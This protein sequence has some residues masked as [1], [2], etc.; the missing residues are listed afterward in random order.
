MTRLVTLHRPLT[1]REAEALELLA[2]APSIADLAA[3][4]QCSPRTARCYVDGIDAKLPAD[5]L[6]EAAPRDRVI[7][8][9]V[10]VWVERQQTASHAA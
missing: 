8:Y 2:E 7:V 9:A 1:Q 10:R 6:P 3:R 5:F 4:M